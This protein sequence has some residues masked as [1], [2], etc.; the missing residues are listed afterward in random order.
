MKLLFV[1]SLKSNFSVIQM[2]TDK[3]LIKNDILKK[4][5]L[6]KNGSNLHSNLTDLVTLENYVQCS[7]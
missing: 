2:N 7:R 3:R 4:G 6:E 5:Y 1:T